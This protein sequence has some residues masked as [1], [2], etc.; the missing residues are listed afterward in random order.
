MRG[1]L[2]S[3]SPSAVDWRR[4][5]QRSLIGAMFAVAAV[6]L[7]LIAVGPQYG[8][9]FRGGT[10]QAGHA[11]LTG[12]SPY[13][14]PDPANLLHIANAFIT[15]PLLAV[16]GAPLSLLPFT[17]ATAVWNIAC[18]VALVAALRLLGVRDRRF[19]ALVLCSFPFISS[20][21]FGQP[22]GAFALLA[23]IAWRWRDS[24][25]GAIAVG[26]LIAAKLLAWPLVLW[27]VVTRR[28][29]LAA[30]AAL[31]AAGWLVASW[32]CI[33]FKGLGQYPRLLSAETRAYGPRS[34]SFVAAIER[35]GLSLLLAQMLAVV[36]ATVI[37]VAIVLAAQRK[38]EGWFT[39]ALAVG[40]LVS[41]VMWQ[42]YLVLLFVPLAITRRFTDPLI[43]LLAIALWLSP[44]E[45]P[46]TTWQTWLV[47][48]IAGAMMIRAVGGGNLRR[49]HQA[50]AYPNASLRRAEA[51]TLSA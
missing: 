43:W 27:L 38:D 12:G 7:L 19:F 13:P 10:W 32:A 30:I 18:V 25:R 26:A 35:L 23:A 48:L 41:P 6:Q 15:P 2:R 40:L 33:G 4:L 11:L 44:V 14:A 22:D 16:V 17:M 39:A 28:I 29:G 37:G 3:S 36:L 1:G 20:I 31:S 50:L 42:H 49:E 8:F 9:D 51:P 24:P 46:P 34:H 21:A 5:A 47:P 45:S